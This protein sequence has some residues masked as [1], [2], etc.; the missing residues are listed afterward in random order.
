LRLR[1]SFPNGSGGRCTREPPDALVTLA[2]AELDDA[3]RR[4]P[5]WP[6]T[7]PASWLGARLIRAQRITSAALAEITTLDLVHPAVTP[8][9]AQVPPAEEAGLTRATLRSVGRVPRNPRT[10]DGAPRC[11]GHAVYGH[12]RTLAQLAWTVEAVGAVLHRVTGTASAAGP[13]PARAATIDVGLE[14][15]LLAVR[16]APVEAD[17]DTRLSLVADAELR[18]AAFADPRAAQLPVETHR[19]ASASEL[20]SSG[21]EPPSSASGSD[22]GTSGPQPAAKAKAI[23]QRVTISH[24]SWRNGPSSPIPAGHLWVAGPRGARSTG[25]DPPPWWTPGGSSMSCGGDASS[26]WVVGNMSS[27]AEPRRLES[28]AARRGARRWR[29][30]DT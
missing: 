10:R 30:G 7:A 11:A 14:T 2:A 6:R 19:P 17:A 4:H 9:H 15:V 20:A 5:S 26:P 1:T 22:A 13:I 24:S 27:R 29:S 3:A 12:G 16:E 8:T 28:R 21:P 18:S 25:I 23:T